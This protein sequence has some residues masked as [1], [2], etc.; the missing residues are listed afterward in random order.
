MKSLDAVRQGPDWIHINFE[1]EKTFQKR[2][3]LEWGQNLCHTSLV[4][5]FS[6]EKEIEGFLQKTWQTVARPWG[7]WPASRNIIQNI[8]I[9]SRKVHGVN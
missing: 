6:Y 4:T 8:K 5:I 3:F 7:Y 1:S 9:F 2:S